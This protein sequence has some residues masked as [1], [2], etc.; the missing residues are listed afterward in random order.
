[1]DLPYNSRVKK[2]QSKGVAVY[3]FNCFSILIRVLEDFM[4]AEAS[5]CAF[6]CTDFGW[7]IFRRESYSLRISQVVST[8]CQDLRDHGHHTT[9]SLCALLREL[10]RLLNL[11]PG[12]HGYLLPDHVDRLLDCMLPLVESETTSDCLLEQLCKV[13]LCKS[14]VVKTANHTCNWRA[15]TQ[16]WSR[17]YAD[18]NKVIPELFV[19]CV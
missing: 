2:R 17:M 12:K 10:A 14:F 19:S 11:V 9:E 13:I 4:S 15:I 5:C 18:G 7:S 16:R 3:A 8:V 6:L 1:M